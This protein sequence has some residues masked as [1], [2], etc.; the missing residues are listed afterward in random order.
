MVKFFIIIGLLLFLGSGC[1]DQVEER[2][3]NTAT[4]IY[5]NLS[6]AQADSIVYSFAKVVEN[7]HVIEVPVEIAGYPAD[8]DRH[9]RV[10]VDETLSTAKV[11]LH[12]D[13]L[14]ES[15]VLPKGTFTTKVPVTVYSTDKLLDSVAVSIAL[16]IVA[17]DEFPND[18]SKRHQALIKVSN[19]L[20]KPG[21]WDLVYGKKYFG[22]WSKTKYRLIFQ[23]CGVEELPA[24]NGPNRYL[25]KGYGMKMQNYFK[26]NYPVYDEN[27]QVIESDWAIIF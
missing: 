9:F 4:T 11:G 16:Q 26:E 2:F 17:K 8:Y 7:S 1:T 3:N 13:A 10:A 14:E 25:L 21:M 22:T 15:Y 5:F 27:G 18:F 23:V 6:G 19:M 24:Y 20:E 12:Y